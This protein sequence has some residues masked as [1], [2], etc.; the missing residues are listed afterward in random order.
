MKILIISGFLGAGKTTFIKALQRHTGREFVILENEFGDVDVDACV[1]EQ[2]S[3]KVWE[4]TEGCICC[5][6]KAD[7]AN[8]VLTISNALD[9]DYLVVEPSGVG[10]LSNICANLNKIRYERIRLLAP[11]TI[12]DF[13]CCSEYLE[14]FDAFY[15]DQIINGGRVLISKGENASSQEL[16]AMGERLKELNPKGEII[17][18]HYEKQPETW[19]KSLLT[20]GWDEKRGIVPM[21]DYPLDMMSLSFKDISYPDLE[22]FQG[23]MAAL[24]DGRFG[25]I[26]RIKGL[27]PIGG[28][29]SKV[30]IV[31]RQYA[32]ETW[33]RREPAR[34]VI[35]GR[36]LDKVGLTALFRAHAK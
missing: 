11:I 5:S 8:S 21:G 12:V 18:E 15:R 32:L 9:P 26:Y 31:N 28:Q 34:L 6:V 17:S 10:L 19:W 1:L 23:E 13:H 7:F 2:D 3:M 35:I 20:T 14:T 27:L 4:L 33:E 25:K 24:T 16:S 30:D 29:W 22:Q 36:N